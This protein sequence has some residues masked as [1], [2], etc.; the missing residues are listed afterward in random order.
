M[1]RMVEWTVLK[2]K[3][4]RIDIN[5]VEGS[6]STILSVCEDFNRLD[7]PHLWTEWLALNLAEKGEAYEFS[8]DFD[9]YILTNFGISR[10]GRMKDA[11]RRNKNE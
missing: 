5:D 11:G 8:K 4:P 6:Y 1:E 3:F 2:M 10:E 9:Q 7:R